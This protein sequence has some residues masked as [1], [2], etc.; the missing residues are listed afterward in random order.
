MSEFTDIVDNGMPDPRVLFKDVD[1]GARVIVA[2]SG[3]SDS[4]ALLLLASAWAHFDDVH[5]QAVTI[6]HGLRPEAAA[7]A[8]YVASLCEGLGIRHV[9]LAWEGIKPNSGLPEAARLARY[10]LL[11]EYAVDAGASYILTGH[12]ADDQVETVYMRL[13]REQAGGT[14]RG[15]SGMAGVT[16][17]PKGVLLL[18]PLLDVSRQVLRDYLAQNSQSW[19]EDPSNEDVSYER[20]RARQFLADKPQH[21]NNL[22][23]YSKVMGRLRKH[24]AGEAANFLRANVSVLPGLVYKLDLAQF[25]QTPEPILVHVLQ[26]LLG[27]VGGGQY[28]VSASKLR[29]LLAGIRN[30]GELSKRQTLANCVLEFKADSILLYR[31]ARNLPS[32][33]LGPGDNA[34]W[35][36]RLHINNESSSSLYVGPLDTALLAEAEFDGENQNS[37]RINVSP[38]AAL[39][40]LPVLRGDGDDL[41]FPML[42]NKALPSGVSTRLTARALAQF[43]PDFDEAL[44]NWLEEL[45]QLVKNSALLARGV[46]D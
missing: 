17:M 2:V 11:E 32:F 30:P 16:V 15:L 4:V 8:A 38:R 39:Q 22:H 3:G 34:V 7:E 19:I 35:D 21:K 28:L 10:Q 42:F 9:T 26:V 18:R 36:G 40:S 46:T 23:I 24:I 12:T 5:V 44:F 20:V 14:G 41:H 43:C 13:S 29:P 31:E 25:K 45:G 1:P 37:K 6:D 27:V 33:L